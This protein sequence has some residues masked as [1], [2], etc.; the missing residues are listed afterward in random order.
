MPVLTFILFLG[1]LETTLFER[2][3]MNQRLIGIINT[4]GLNSS[5]ERLVTA[6]AQHFGAKEMGTLMS[7]MRAFESSPQSMDQHQSKNAEKLDRLI[8][9]LLQAYETGSGVHG[10]GNSAGTNVQSWRQAVRLG[11]KHENF[12]R[13]GVSFSATNRV[14]QDSYVAVGRRVPDDWH[15]AH[16]LSIFT[17]THKGPT[18]EL[19][20]HTETYFVVQK[21]EELTPMDATRDP[22][23]KF[24]VIGGR[25]Y[26]DKVKAPELVTPEEIL[27]HFA[28]TPFEHPHIAP[29]CI[30]A[31]PLDR[32]CWFN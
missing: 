5:L 6:F 12:S 15:A 28:Y 9:E 1:Q 8:C 18:W 26:Y 17:Y 29:A 27:C 23:R 14:Q 11:I 32:V 16:I 20:G 4:F 22:Y 2:F 13:Y 25:L 21:Y 19:M 30:H 24:P 10:L 7:D 3:C 31:L